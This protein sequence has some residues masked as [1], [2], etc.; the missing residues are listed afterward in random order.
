M[1]YV[2]WFREVAECT[3]HRWQ[4]RLGNESKC[5]NRLFRVPTGLGKTAGTV[6]AWAYHR[7]YRKVV[8]WPM[9]LVFCLPMRVLVEQT[10]RA[11][12]RWLERGKLDVRVV[13][14]L[15]GRREVEWLQYPER[16]TVLVGT[17][18]MLLTRAMARGHGS[19]RGLWPMEMGML[20]RDALWVVDE[21]QL[22]DVG[23]ATTT[24]LHAFRGDDEADGKPTLRKTFTWWMSATLQS[25]WLETIDFARR[26]EKE[27]ISQVRIP[28][29]ERTGSAWKN[30]KSLERR[31]D[32]GTPEEVAEL[33]ASSHRPGSLTLVIVNTVERAKKVEAALSKSRMKADVHLVHSRFRGA[34]RRQWD[35]LARESTIPPEGRIILS[36]QVIEAGVDISA[37]TLI[38]D[39]APWS[40][41]VQRFGRCAR[42]PNEKG[43]IVIV[44]AV[45]CENPEKSLP[46]KINEI[47]AS[48]A[49]L[50]ELSLDGRDLGL[51]SLETFEE[52][53]TERDPDALATLYPYDPLHVLRRR[54]FDDLFDTT[55]DLS[56]ADLDVSRY[57][58]SGEDRDVS[59]FWREIGNPGRRSLQDI[60]APARDE[61]C[62]V[63]V[64][65]LREFLKKSVGYVRDYLSGDWK[66]IDVAVPGMTVLIP[67]AAGGYTARSGWDPKSD[68]VV[69]S[70]AISRDELAHE[71]QMTSTAASSD[72]EELSMSKWK[73]IATHGR[74]T[75]EL[76]VGM[77]RSLGFSDSLLRVL[78]L[79]GRWHDAGKAHLVFQ[80]AIRDEIRASETVGA[81]RDLAKAPKEAWKKPPYPNRP[82]FRHELVSTL[83]LFEVLRRT[84]PGHP[85][86]V[87][88]HGDLLRALGLSVD[89]DAPSDEERIV[90]HSLADEIAS[91]TADEFDLLAYLVCSHHGKVRTSWSSTPK[92]QKNEQ[93]DIHGVREGDVV[94]PFFIAGHGATKYEIPNVHLS[95]ACASMGLN[96]RYGASWGE[97]VAKLLARLG[98]FSLAYLEAI[99]RAA[100]WR[101]SQ[102]ATAEDT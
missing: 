101:A 87:A 65:E 22:M 69:P 62:P 60:E 72:G 30:P 99:L 21:V 35:F 97:R 8:H 58:R 73:T 57:I 42:Y 82:G 95:L 54:D 41:L 18:D 36:T 55:P 33:A 20:H 4:E 76:V 78:S 9:R 3:P 100:D 75:G 80:N 7:A 6:L 90:N 98:P 1:D 17:Q 45:D 25:S 2:D 84:N 91:L 48:D 67:S 47:A 5:D 79:A 63:P 34:E 68:A 77:G 59:V 71:S 51:R 50:R 94:M 64:G 44:G 61:L 89:A 40:S 86:L 32:V 12:R 52:L 14:L 24:Q 13:T 85:A 38:S 83:L 46:Y 16:P 92:D 66:R 26:I 88:P 93:G 96:A 37:S 39:L 23:L 11:V 10:E 31:T 19:A 28:A 49:A 27:P 29:R 53:L 102:L 56:G 74:E 70:P 43:R 81:R 15:G